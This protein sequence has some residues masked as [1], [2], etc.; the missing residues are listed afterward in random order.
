MPGHGHLRRRLHVPADPD[1]HDAWSTT[2]H[3]VRHGPDQTHH[4]RPRT[5]TTTTLVG[6]CFDIDGHVTAQACT[7]KDDC[8]SNPDGHSGHFACCGDGMSDFGETCDKGTANCAAA[9]FCPSDCTAD[10]QSIGRCTGNGAQCLDA[11]TDCPAGQGCCG[12]RTVDPGETCDDGNFVAARVTTVPATCFI[13]SCTAVPASSFGTHVTFTHPAGTTISGLG[14][15]VDYPEGKITAAT[16]DITAVRRER[17]PE[18]P[19]S[20]RSVSRP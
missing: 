17:R 1:H 7:S 4:E 3:H 9:T 15:F 10:C 14:F 2:Y 19:A 13:A 6:A 5:T 8:P 18:R 11:A 12:N 20:T 16:K